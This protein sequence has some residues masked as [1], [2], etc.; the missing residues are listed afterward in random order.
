MDFLEKIGYTDAS[1]RLRKRFSH[2]SQSLPE[3]NPYFTKAFQS[4]P[5]LG[6]IFEN[7]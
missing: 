5:S 1:K 2:Y 6:V 7:N 4:G 3:V